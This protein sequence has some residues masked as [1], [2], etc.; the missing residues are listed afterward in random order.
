[1]IVYFMLYSLIYIISSSIN[2][3]DDGVEEEDIVFSYQLNVLGPTVGVE[4][5]PNMLSTCWVAQF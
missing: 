3:N 5:L 1:M 2:D 4:M